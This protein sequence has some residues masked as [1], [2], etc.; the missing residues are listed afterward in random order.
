MEKK[1]LQTTVFMREHG[2]GLVK[3]WR[4]CVGAGTASHGLRAEWQRQFE[5]T[6]AQCGFE[7]A[8]LSDWGKPDM[9]DARETDALCDFLCDH[10][11]APIVRLSAGDSVDLNGFARHAI[12]RYGAKRVHN[13]KF[14]T[15][16][17]KG[18][19]QKAKLLKTVDSSLS[20]GVVVPIPARGL[21]SRESG[22]P[23][24]QNCGFVGDPGEREA[25]FPIAHAADSGLK[26]LMQSPCVAGLKSAAANKDVDFAVLSGSVDSVEDKTYTRVMEALAKLQGLP[27]H[28]DGIDAAHKQEDALTDAVAL[29]KRHLGLDSTDGK[30]SP[31]QS[32]SL[33]SF[34][35]ICRQGAYLVDDFG[36]R[37]PSGHAFRMMDLL[38][39]NELDRGK[40]YIV[41]KN[42]RGKVCAMA[43]SDSANPDSLE[44][45]GLAPYEK[46]MLETLDAE[47][48][49]AY[50]TWRQM[51]CP[52][53]PTRYQAQALRQAALATDVKF[54]RAD[55]RGVFSLPL[56][57]GEPT[58]ML[59]KA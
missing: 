29:T 57:K 33:V 25:F 12:S 51:G 5:V 14:E 17:T 23:P 37:Q 40:G 46:L 41:T 43:W 10:N 45:T 34:S 16:H 13:W 30:M 50:M 59:L 49:F 7:H 27:L 11:I 42:E 2:K 32:L 36:V 3:K 55:S 31:L 39:D 24:R 8:R 54:C 52:A 44:I 53:S 47:H 35:G 6:V 38:Y 26:G 18:F 19:E 56:P 22:K 9:K 15:P 1:P 4:A 20:V 48:G 58:I 28:L 21:R